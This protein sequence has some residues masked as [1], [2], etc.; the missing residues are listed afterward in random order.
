MLDR[1][2]EISEFHAARAHPETV[3]DIEKD[4]AYLTAWVSGERVLYVGSGD[5]DGVVDFSALDDESVV[6]SDD[7]TRVA[8]TL[9]A[10]T[11][12]KPVLDLENNYVVNHDRGIV[13]KWKGSD[14]ERHSCA[15]WSR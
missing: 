10:A 3:V 11:V 2:T 13:D 5:V 15:Q 8:I 9:P 1:C 6:A 14:L 7:G 4:T 12:G